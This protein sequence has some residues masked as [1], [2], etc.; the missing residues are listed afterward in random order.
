MKEVDEKNKDNEIDMLATDADVPIEDLI[1]LYYP[2]QYKVS[3][4][5]EASLSFAQI[6]GTSIF[7]VLRTRLYY[8]DI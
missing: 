7:P 1:K 3:K 8:P 2:D 4:I 6:V 5:I